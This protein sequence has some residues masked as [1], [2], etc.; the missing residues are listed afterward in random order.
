MGLEADCTVRHGRRKSAG[1]A[2][3]EEKDV[4]FRGDFRLDIPFA[5][6]SS[7]E[8]KRGMLRIAF[9]GGT[10]E[11][12]LGAAAEKWALKIRYPKPL[13]EKIGIKPG[14]RVLLAGK[15]EAIGAESFWRELRERAEVVVRGK[16]LDCVLFFAA[17]TAELS[18]RRRHAGSSSRM[19]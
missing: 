13:I 14:M 16:D 17:A 1:K 11:F 19:A 5:E 12:Q 4:Q 3:L 6:I 15:H 10:A 9:S 7:T 2:R 18:R 8:A